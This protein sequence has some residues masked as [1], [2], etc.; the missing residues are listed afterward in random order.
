MLA[1]KP[2]TLDLSQD[3]E[4]VLKQVLPKMPLLTS[5]DTDWDGIYFAYGNYQNPGESQEVISPQHNILI[6]TEIPE[7][8]SAERK[9]DG[10]L[11]QEKVRQGDVVIIPANVS[12]QVQWHNAGSF[13]MLGVD[14]KVFNHA[15]YETV[16]PDRVEIA[17]HHAQADPLIYQIALKLKTEV[18]SGG[19][20]S[21]LYADA[22][23]NLLSVHLLQHY[24]IQKPQIHNYTN[25]L[26]KYKLQ[27][28]IEYINA[29]LERSLSLNELAQVV[30]MS[31]GYFSRLFKQSTGFTPHQ[32]LIRCRVKRAREL[33]CQRKLTI[34]EVAY[35]VGFA[36][37]GHLNY[38]FKRLTGITPKTM[39][40]NQ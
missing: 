33:L 31:P 6:F 1:Q 3:Q 13:I 39:Q 35:Q 17:P 14:A 22:I 36:N 30:Q 5:K 11:K 32:Y 2:I 34:A 25:G 29:H 40:L 20:G 21:R 15:L 10:S 27:Q 4:E 18:E 8:I 19:L 7:F 37:Q 24:S 12:H 9:F 28:I 16:E 23:A 38:H 26:P